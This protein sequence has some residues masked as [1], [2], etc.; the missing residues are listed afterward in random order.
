MK[1]LL[2]LLLGHRFTEWFI[3]WDDN[4][5]SHRLWPCTRCGALYR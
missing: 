4:A 2:C 3:L 5:N 1:A